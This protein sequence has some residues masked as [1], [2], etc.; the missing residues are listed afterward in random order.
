MQTVPTRRRFLSGAALA[1]AGAMLPARRGWSEPA[2]ETR[3]V[4]LTKFGGLCLSPQYVAE[5]LLR[6]EGLTD[7]SYVDIDKRRTSLTAAI[8]ETTPTSPSISR[9]ISSKRSTP[10]RG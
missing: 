10:A 7:V 6:T 9:R 8:A 3:S 5:A 4:R 2:L 1:G